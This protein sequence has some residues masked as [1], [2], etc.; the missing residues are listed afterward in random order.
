MFTHEAFLSP[1]TWRYGSEEMRRVWSEEHR[2]RLMR[3]V[4]VALARA[5][6][7]AGLLRPEQVA[8]LEAHQDDI[9]LGRA[10]EIESRVRHDVVAELR[11]FAEQAPL[12]GP[13]LHLGATSADITDNADALRLRQALEI[14]LRRLAE[15]LLSLAGP[16]ESRAGQPCIAWTHLQPAEPTTVGYRLSLYA[17]DLLADYQ[18]LLHLQRNIYG[19]GLKGAVGTAAAFAQLL[20]GSLLTPEAL[21]ERFMALLGLEAFPATGQTYPRRQ[22]YRV[23]CALASLGASLYKFAFD[24]RFLQSPPVGE[25][26]EPFAAEQVGSSAMPFKRNPVNAEKVDSLARLLAAL[27]RVAWDNAAHSLLERTLDD[28]AN[29]R[30]VLPVA[31]LAADELLLTATSLVREMRFDDAAIAANLARY[32]T[33][34]AT[35]RLLMELVQ[36]GADRQEMHE[37]L[38]RHS[39][40]AW[41]AIRAG[42][43]NPLPQSLAADPEVRRYLP[44]ERLQAL[45]DVSRYLGLAPKRAREMARRVREV[46]G[47]G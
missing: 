14:L 2:R 44:E 37:R 36:A 21:E 31:F 35:E 16:I 15:L 30:E 5:Q 43:P 23:L 47:S 45:L 40:A 20:E 17:Q 33:F 13:V 18:D 3:R 41:E 6:C 22:D 9:D 28:S 29:R 26:S 4:W 46:V 8:D 19:K 25:W 7:E 12:G 38:R 1:F 27:P 39:L 34:A 10:A 32:G 11:T 42:R 24:L